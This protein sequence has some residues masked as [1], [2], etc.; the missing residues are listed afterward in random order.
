MTELTP[1]GPGHDRPPSVATPPSAAGSSSPA[2]PP[3]R[4]L[5]HRPPAALRHDDRLSTVAVS[6]L[7][8]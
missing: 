1:T 6:R 5:P 7:W 2:W 3:G 8:R 4:G